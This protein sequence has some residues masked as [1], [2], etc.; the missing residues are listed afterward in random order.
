MSKQLFNIIV[1]SEFFLGFF[2]EQNFQKNIY[3]N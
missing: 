1:E 2:D 3:V